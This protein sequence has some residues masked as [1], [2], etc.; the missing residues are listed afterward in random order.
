MKNILH[1]IYVLSFA[2]IALM[3][4][5]C[6]EL[7]DC[8]ARARPNLHSKTLVT[9]ISGNPYYD[10]IESDVTNDPNDNDYDYFY[11]VDGPIPPGLTY[12]RQG[13]RLIFTGT[14][15]IAGTYIFKVRLT[16]DPPDDFSPGHGLFDDSNRI[17]FN[18]DTITK[19]FKIV[20]Q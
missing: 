8:I 10:Y 3:I 17:C 20:I 5:G 6:S 2:A 12:Y 9:G 11:A 16:V 1:K 4:A 7:T 18:D 19:E 13:R 15:R 14:P